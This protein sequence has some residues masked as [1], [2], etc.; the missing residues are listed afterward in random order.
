MLNIVYFIFSTFEIDYFNSNWFLSS[1]VNAESIQLKKFSFVRGLLYI[2]IVPRF[3]L[4]STFYL[5]LF[6]ASLPFKYFTKRS[7]ACVSFVTM[8]KEVVMWLKVDLLSNAINNGIKKSINTWL[9]CI[10]INM[11]LYV[12]VWY[13]KVRDQMYVEQYSD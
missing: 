9:L 7:F 10:N 1:F 13:K 12:H 8:N 3:P 2:C 5:I 4:R 6:F 11:Y